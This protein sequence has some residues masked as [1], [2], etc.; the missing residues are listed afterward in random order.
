M[1]G[2]LVDPFRQGATN[3]ECCKLTVHLGKQ[4]M[5]RTR[6]SFGR[7]LP[8]AALHR[9]GRAAARRAGARAPP[10]SAGPQGRR[11]AGHSISSPLN[12]RTSAVS[13]ALA[14]VSSN[15]PRSSRTSRTSR[16]GSSAASQ[17]RRRPPA[18][19]HLRQ[20][21]GAA[22]PRPCPPAAAPILEPQRCWKG[23]RPRGAAGWGIAP[24]A[25]A[26][27]Q[28]GDAAVAV[29]REHSWAGAERPT[30]F[31]NRFPLAWSTS[32]EGG[33]QP[34]QRPCL[35]V[36]LLGPAPLEAA[37]LGLGGSVSEW[38]ASSAHRCAQSGHWRPPS[39]R[40]ELGLT[41]R[42]QP[43]RPPPSLGALEG[44]LLRA[45]WF[46]SLGADPALAE[47]ESAPR[48]IGWARWG[49]A[50]P[51]CAAAASFRQWREAQPLPRRA[52]EACQHPRRHR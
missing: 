40:V 17:G 7:C 5:Q 6:D 23:C 52:M 12:C 2:E 51:R 38:P 33:Q 36:R 44:A 47:R 4:R 32:G 18:S 14:G 16:T 25:T 29:V 35:E 39:R 8:M 24:P 46:P 13:R 43:P 26:A 45:A 50:P 48:S 30:H 10:P 21:P 28:M 20:H 22:R 19:H 11:L 27:F 41:R 37:E 1:R 3:V 42:E 15:D 34:L 31:L 9:R 49:W